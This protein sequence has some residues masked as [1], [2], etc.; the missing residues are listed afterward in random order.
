MVPLIT[1]ISVLEPLSQR[2]NF[3]NRKTLDF[4]LSSVRFSIFQTNFYSKTVSGSVSVSELFFGF[5]SSQNFRI[6]SESDSDPQHCFLVLVNCEVRRQIVVYGI[7]YTADL[8]T[9]YLV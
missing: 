5:G 9:F 1:F 8:T 7:G 3:V 2:K 6:L 4:S